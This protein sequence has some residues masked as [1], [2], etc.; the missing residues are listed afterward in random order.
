MTTE[1][2]DPKLATVE[3]KKNRRKRS[4]SG[5]VDKAEKLRDKIQQLLRKQWESRLQLVD[6]KTET[7]VPLERYKFLSNSYCWLYSIECF[8][9][10][11]RRSKKVVPARCQC[12]H[13]P[14]MKMSFTSVGG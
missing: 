10:V 6:V 13:H 3:K 1:V 9:A 8:L 2:V 12:L 4:P 14:L 7:A 5:E 11:N